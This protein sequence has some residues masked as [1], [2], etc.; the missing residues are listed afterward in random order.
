M[1]SCT[2]AL[3]S[4]SFLAVAQGPPA[5]P[6]ARPSTP[7]DRDWLLAESER[8]SRSPYVEPRQDGLGPLAD[9]SYEAY[10]ALRFEPGAAIWE[11]EGRGFTVDL[12]HPGFIYRTPVDIN[13]VVGG[14]AR[15]V[16]FTP[17][18]FEYAPG[19]PKPP[20][21]AP[22]GYSGLRLRHA[23]NKPGVMDEF[24]VFQ[25]ASYFRAVGRGQGYGVS[26]RGLAVRTADP[27]GEEF[28]AFTDF[29]IERPPE[30][31]EQIRLHALLDSPS[32][33]GAYTFDVDPGESTVVTVEMSLFPRVDIRRFGIAP[34]TSMFLFDGTNHARFDDFRDAAHDSDGLQIVTGAGERLWRPLANPQTLQISSF[35]DE[36]PKGFGLAQR[37]RDVDDFHDYEAAYERRPTLWV[38]P[39]EGWGHGSV[40]LIEIPSQR[41][42][43]DN[44]VAY[45][46]PATPLVAGRRHDYSYR[47]SWGP[48]ARDPEP[49]ARV[50]STRS[51]LAADGE[52]RRIVID[53][54]PPQGAAIP[55]GLRVEVKASQGTITNV[56]SKGFPS[57]RRYRVGF[58][59]DPG[60]A[61]LIELRV[62]V[63][64]DNRPWGET[65][66]YRWTP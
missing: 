3:L 17:E 38:E 33:T 46:Q 12:L 58:D 42:V 65:W 20:P 40:D 44:I 48:D 29:W 45:W 13:L 37:K 25:G 41:D 4:L 53:Y 50:V 24:L 32:V 22:L 18:V 27:E 57:V 59:L 11:R 16:F 60:G 34:L 26:A 7:F 52:H 56:R 19:I 28:P 14:R 62:M 23:I 66:L 10:R 43:H 2:L 55:N 1:A 15:K 21:D 5:D 54:A 6:K 47:L 64:Q 9:I 51:G 36:S 61:D 30:G 8:L 39:L 35:L 31:A 49:L 63:L